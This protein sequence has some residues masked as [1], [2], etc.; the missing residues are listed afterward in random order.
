M[1]TKSKKVSKKPREKK[2]KIKQ[3]DFI[4]SEVAESVL[5]ESLGG[6]QVFGVEPI[7]ESAEFMDSM[8]QLKEKLES[9]DKIQDNS[10]QNNDADGSFRSGFLFFI[11]FFL[12]GFL[13]F[14][15]FYFIF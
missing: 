8:R 4:D 3:I 1:P 14:V 10:V 2:N 12:I 5:E 11:L 7:S 13:I 9:R 6:G 15:I